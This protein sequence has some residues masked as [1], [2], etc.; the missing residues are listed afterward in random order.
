MRR[1]GL[2]DQGGHG[3]PWRGREAARVV[4]RIELH[5][6]ALGEALGDRQLAR[7]AADLG[8]KNDLAAD[9]AHLGFLSARTWELR[10]WVEATG[11]QMSR[12]I[13][14]G[15]PVGVRVVSDP[16]VCVD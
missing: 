12:S 8:E 15:E 2:A 13:E 1:A 3:L 11:A 16:A 10:R 6:R 14:T 9:P 4:A 7:L 5:H